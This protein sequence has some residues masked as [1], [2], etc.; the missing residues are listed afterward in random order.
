MLKTVQT[1]TGGGGGGN[2]TVTLVATGT[3]LTGGPITSSGTIRL[4]NT[5]VTAGDYGNATTVP[6]LTIDAQ[7]RITAA[8][9]VTIS[10]GGGGNGTVTNVTATSPLVST[11]GAT[12][13]LSI[14][15]ANATTNGYLTSADWTTFNGKG[16]GTVTSVTGT[17]NV[18]STGG[19]TPVIDLADT[20]VMPG[21]YGDSTHVAQIT[22]DAKGRVTSAANVTISGGGGNGGSGNINTAISYAWFIS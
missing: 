17:A 4:A 10:G 14:P 11:Y 3:G 20:A 7:G 18:T 1:G 12:P 13:N 5:A 15:A 9:N 22:I 6:V 21:V 2:G 19:T 8:A 16:T